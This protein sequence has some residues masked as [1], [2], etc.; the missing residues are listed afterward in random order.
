[1]IEGRKNYL[2]NF[3]AFRV[4]EDKDENLS[5]AACELGI[6]HQN[7]QMWKHQSD[8]ILKA[9]KSCD[10]NTRNDCCMRGTKAM[11]PLLDQELVKFIKEKNLH[12]KVCAIQKCAQNIFPTLYPEV[13]GQL[14]ALHGFVNRFLRRNN[15]TTHRV[16]GVGQK[17]PNN[18]P[19]LCDQFPDDMQS[20]SRG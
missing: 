19:E 3:K 15:L 4:L 7:L 1:M 16:T 9:V 18:A 8:R 12:A 20:R 10:V 2:L 14:K 17:V 13:Q 6:T 11:Y 5:Q